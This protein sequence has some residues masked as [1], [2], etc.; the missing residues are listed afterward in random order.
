MII[1]SFYVPY[2]WLLMQIKK[3]LERLEFCL[4]SYISRRCFMEEVIRMIQQNKACPLFLG[5]HSIPLYEIKK[6]VNH[7]H[8]KKVSGGCGTRQSS[9]S[10]S[11]SCRQFLINWDEGN[12]FVS[13]WTWGIYAFSNIQNQ[14]TLFSHIL[15]RVQRESPRTR[16]KIFQKL[17]SSL[18]VKILWK[19]VKSKLDSVQKYK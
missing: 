11:P 19:Q 3:W 12:Y 4:K 17:Y 8:R 2:I 18:R 5:M 6:N 1:L 10:I 7:I 14:V 13:R 9:I 15:M 16:C